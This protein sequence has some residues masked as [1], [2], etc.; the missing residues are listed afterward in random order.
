MVGPSCVVVFLAG[1]NEAAFYHLC[2]EK[3]TAHFI[4]Y[5]CLHSM[6]GCKIHFV[7]LSQLTLDQ[8]ILI[9]SLKTNFMCEI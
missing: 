4:V 3:V 7:L 9:K 8:L 1:N 6:C 5:F 2:S